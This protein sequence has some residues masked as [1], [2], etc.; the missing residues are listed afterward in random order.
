MQVRIKTG[1]RIYY[2]AGKMILDEFITDDAITNSGKGINP[3]IAAKALT[4]RK[5]AV[6]DVSERNGH[7]YAYRLLPYKIRVTREYF[8][9]GTD[10]FKTAKRKAQMGLWDDAGELWKKETGNH[11]S[12]IAGRAAYN[13]AIISEINGDLSEALKWAQKAWGDYNIKLALDYTRI[14]ENRLYKSDVLKEQGN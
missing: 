1:W 5:E 7:N 4:G 8:V 11:D 2:P 10:N 14:L 9:K 12:K 13:M 6:R 3:L